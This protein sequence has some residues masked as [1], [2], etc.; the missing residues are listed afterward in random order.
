VR[1][2]VRDLVVELTELAAEP[3]DHDWLTGAWEQ[4]RP[5]R[6][7]AQ[8][9]PPEQEQVLPPG[10]FRLRYSTWSHAGYALSASERKIV[11]EL[12]TRGVQVWA[13]EVE[14]GYPLRPDDVVVLTSLDD[15]GN[16]V[17]LWPP[18]RVL[19][20]GRPRHTSQSV[21]VRHSKKLAPLPVDDPKVRAIVRGLRHDT[22]VGPASRARLLALWDLT[23]HAK[24][25]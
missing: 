19:R 4:Y 6:R 13:W 5:P 18:M 21:F 12:S 8:R 24:K 22:W 2:Q 15:D 9:R 10:P 25:Q 1:H 11:D 16:P 7:S 20:L 17:E 3:L 14:P 23:D